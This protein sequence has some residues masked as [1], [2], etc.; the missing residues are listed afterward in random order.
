MCWVLKQPILT[1]RTPKIVITLELKYKTHIFG[2]LEKSQKWSFLEFGAV[3]GHVTM[4]LQCFDAFS[5]ATLAIL[6]VFTPTHP[7]LRGIHVDIATSPP[8]LL[9]Q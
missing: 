9:Q 1:S 3:F 2:I 8:P 5:D 6:E 7:L 4:Q